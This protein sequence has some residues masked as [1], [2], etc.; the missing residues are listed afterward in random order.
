M[1]PAS[2]FE[3][4]TSSS[5]MKGCRSAPAADPPNCDIR[6]ERGSPPSPGF[7]GYT[8][9]GEGPL[10]DSTPRGGESDGGATLCPTSRAETAPP[11]VGAAGPPLAD[12][13]RAGPRPGYGG[14][15]SDRRCAGLDDHR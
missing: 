9:P 6:G 11:G 14:G 5:P 7:A 3:P 8:Q 12:V 1:E 10:A 13:G 4:E 2:G 15:A